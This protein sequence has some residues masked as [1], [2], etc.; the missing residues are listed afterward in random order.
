[1]RVLAS[2]TDGET[3]IFSGRVDFQ[4]EPTAGCL[5]WTGWLK[6]P[7]GEVHALALWANEQVEVVVPGEASGSALLQKGRLRAGIHIARE[8]ISVVGISPCPLRT[9]CETGAS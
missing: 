1:M 2:I 9:R 5:A 6:L 3:E 4:C 7:P 8:A